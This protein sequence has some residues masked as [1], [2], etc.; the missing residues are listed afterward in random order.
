VQLDFFLDRGRRNGIGKEEEKSAV[1]QN[2]RRTRGERGKRLL[3]QRGE[4]V[5]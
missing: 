5:E 2:R 4:R 1:Y 3:R